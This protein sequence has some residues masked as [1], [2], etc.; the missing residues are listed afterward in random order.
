[1]KKLFLLTVSLLCS[2][3]SLAKNIGKDG[4][5]TFILG[6]SAFY[7]SA[8]NS[9]ATGS[10]HS[11]NTIYDLKGGYVTSKGL[12]IGGLLTSR[13]DDLGGAASTGGSQ[14]GASVGYYGSS[15]IHF[16]GHYIFSAK[17]GGFAGAYE[18][19]SGLQADFGYLSAVT[20]NFFIGVDL[21]YRNLTYKELNGAKLPSNFT[22]TELFPML[23]LMFTL[24]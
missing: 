22:R 18:Q 11:T 23:S 4:D 15:G 13:N 5:N 9:D 20:S 14:T 7:Y 3:I 10:S 1:M 2:Q 19:G 12:F 16:V 24:M 21:S 17:L 6:L 8:N